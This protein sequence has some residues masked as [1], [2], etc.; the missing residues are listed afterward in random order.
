[1]LNHWII[2]DDVASSAR[3]IALSPT[4]DVRRAVIEI[5]H[6]HPLIVDDCRPSELNLWHRDAQL[7]N[8]GTLLAEIDLTGV[9][10][11]IMAP[12]SAIISDEV[13]IV[14]P[15]PAEP[16][17][18]V[19]PAKKTSAKAR[20]RRVGEAVGGGWVKAAARRAKPAESNGGA[21]RCPYK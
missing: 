10:I 4:W 6:R 19:A 20:R 13:P 15:A 21:P 8:D 16:V 12:P 9:P 1:M 2:I 5:A 3:Q 17:V 14:A 18:T 11:T 7:P